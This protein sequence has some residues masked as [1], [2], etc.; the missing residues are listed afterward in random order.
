MVEAALKGVFEN[1]SSL[2][3]KE[4]GLFLGFDQDL[5]KRLASLLT[6]ILAMH[7]D[8]EEK[9]FSDISLKDWLLKLRDAAHELDDIMDEYAYEK[10]QLEYEGV[11]SCLSEFV[12]IS[13]LSSFHPMHVFSYYKTVKKM[14]SISERLEEIAQERIKFHLTVMVHER[15][16]GREKDMDKI[17]DFFVD[18]AFHSKDLLVYPIVGLGRLR[19]TTLVQLI[20]NHEKVVNHSELRIWMLEMLVPG[21]VWNELYWRSFFQ[22]IETHTFGKI[23]RFKMHDLIH[24]LAQFV[25]KE[26]VV[27]AFR[28]T[29]V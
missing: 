1:L 17:V 20:F 6:A 24:D 12:K 14:K 29:M 19:K 15:I 11:N 4:L 2:I 18:D 8:A 26:R 5:K 3:G 22:D 13:C 23:T 7:E 10:L 25:V 9:Q 28:M 21:G 27:V 16:Y